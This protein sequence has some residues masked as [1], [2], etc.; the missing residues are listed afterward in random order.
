MLES[1]YY[2]L[3][4]ACNRACAHCYEERFRP[5]SAEELEPMVA[6]QAERLPAI[7]NHFPETMAFLDLEDQQPDGS[8]RERIGR[9]ILAGGEV[10]L[11]HVRE[12]LLYPA[13]DLLNRR[14][15]PDGVKLVVQTGGEFLDERVLDALLAHGVWTVSVSSLDEYHHR[16][17]D[18]E[19]ERLKDRL[20][21]L[22]ESADMVPSD[23]AAQDLKPM[24]SERLYNF[25]G[26]TPDVW[27]GKLW[28]SGRAW[29][30]NLST[31]EY[32]D[33]FC[34]N[35]SGARGFLDMGLSGSE[36]AVDPDGRVYPCCRKT[37]HPLGDLTREPLDRILKSLV[38]VPAFEALT[39]GAPERMAL[40][41]GL[42]PD[43]FR[44]LSTVRPGGRVYVN[45][46]LGCDAIFRKYLK[47]CL[48]ELSR[49]R[50]NEETG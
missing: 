19:A 24:S 25:F 42:S 20:T 16:P 13:L 11:P 34:A 1:I 28:P 5:Y 6:F 8:F 31:A 38:G 27:I 22:F 26:A 50:A 37:I 29:R 14:Y 45:R 33:N 39:C 35:W 32:K 21:G 41:Y 49:R 46:C 2:S 7:V 9:V 36:V 10:L 40:S 23:R 43:D 17:K 47:P 12:K 44:T 15:G 18:G 4:W 48:D 30:N 3:T